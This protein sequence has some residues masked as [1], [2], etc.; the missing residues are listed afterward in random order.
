MEKKD[1]E[2]AKVSSKLNVSTRAIVAYL[3]S[4]GEAIDNVSNFLLTDE[5]I[6]ILLEEF[7]QTDA[8][9]EKFRDKLMEMLAQ[10]FPNCR[11]MM[12]RI[13]Y[14]GVINVFFVKIG[15]Q[16]TLE[17]HWESINNMIA[18]YY[19][20]KLKSDFQIWNLYLFFI[21]TGQIGRDLKYKIE[22]NTVSSRKIVID[23]Q[24]EDL[25]RTM[26]AELISKHITN[27]SLNTEVATATKQKFVKGAGLGEIID[28]LSATK[29]KGNREG[30]LD[31][32]LSQIEKMLKK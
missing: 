2:L 22:H 21:G 15:D 27:T 13:T 26:T 25:E 14:A 19:Q 20:S 9:I 5:Q 18:V 17:K 24:T 29:K 1:N 32:A 16:E 12:E 28:K 31:D 6:D 3:S 7:S 11:F 10:K 23:E 4:R 8:F 30:A